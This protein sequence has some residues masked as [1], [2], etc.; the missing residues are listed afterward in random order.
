MV[1]TILQRFIESRGYAVQATLKP[2]QIGE[3]LSGA[4]EGWEDGITQ[5]FRIIRETCKEEWMDQARLS[6]QL[7]Y[8]N[9]A[10]QYFYRV[11][12]D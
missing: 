8:L 2:H 3:I 7:E 10:Y 11:I 12:T 4:N 5:P 1:S 9:P 6:G